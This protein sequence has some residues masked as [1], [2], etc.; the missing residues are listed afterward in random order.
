MLAVGLPAPLNLFD[1]PIVVYPKPFLEQVRADGEIG[2]GVGIV[3]LFQFTDTFPAITTS[4]VYLV[5]KSTAKS[6]MGKLNDTKLFV[7]FPMMVP[8]S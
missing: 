8:G 3:N 5:N 6:R 1:V 4:R 2:Y 7:S